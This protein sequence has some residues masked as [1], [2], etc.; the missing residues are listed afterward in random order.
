[1]EFNFTCITSDIFVT[2]IRNDIDECAIVHTNS[3]GSCGFFRD[4]NSNYTISCNFDTYTLTI[5]GSFDIN[6]LHGSNW[7]CS[8]YFGA[9]I[10]NGVILYVNGK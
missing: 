2:I 3:D 8:S 1:M 10:S 6:T 5:P 9:D 7:S 4:C